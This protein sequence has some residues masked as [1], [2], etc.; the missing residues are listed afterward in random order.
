MNKSEFEIYETLD[1]EVPDISP[2]S[3]LYNL[4]P[5][6]IGTARVESLAS[7]ISRLAQEHFQTPIVL[8]KNSV[9]DLSELPK[10]LLQN[11]I[12]ASF[13]KSLNGFGNNTEQI[14]KILQKATFRNDIHK[15]T[16]LMWR[17]KL[18]KHKLLRKN[19]AW[20]SVCYEE[21]KENNQIVY[22]QLLWAF[23]KVSVC[24]LHEIPLTE[25]CP[26]CHN[27][28]KIL[29]RNFK[30]GY[31][32]RCSHWMGGKNIIFDE[33]RRGQKD[34]KHKIEMWKAIKLGELLSKVPLTA[35]KYNEKLFIENLENLIEEISF[36]SIND[37]AY[38][39]EMWHVSIRRLLKGEVL[40]TIEMLLKICTPLDISPA[41]LFIKK[42]KTK[43]PKVVSQNTNI[44][45]LSKNDFKKILYRFFDEYPPLSANEVSRRTGW[46]T[47]RI[48]RN[49][50]NEY[51]MIVKKYSDYIEQ[52]LPKLNNEEVKKILE[53][54][55]YEN[56]PP[57]LQSIFRKIGCRSTGYRYYHK[58]PKLCAKISKRYQKAN[59]KIFDVKKAEKVLKLAL[60]EVPAPSFSEIARRLKCS[61]T[62]L[63]TKFPN[64]SKRLHKRYKDHLDKK[65]K[66]NLQTLR[67]TIKQTIN[68][69]RKQLLPVSANSVRKNMPRKW[70][71]ETFVKEFA[72]I[73]KRM[74]F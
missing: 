12:N 26:H 8:L 21:Q 4:S 54:A 30:S 64:L 65:R 44:K 17:N 67:K 59:K 37:F 58:F 62:T 9:T 57:S 68:E 45:N 23:E 11:S 2:R 43:N 27:K 15:T 49:F 38:L 13:A 46:T 61:R 47:T 41:L 74:G 33:F 40:P 56:P 53:K 69:L 66:A 42:S 35:F 19:L 31:C 72:L 7:Y 50:P 39:T 29:G 28:L 36:G 14:V 1:I 6:E 20:C 48:Q 10:T 18:S 22:D 32:S 63:N 60:K 24:Y 5:L 25:L 55:C 51:E 16:L 70:N 3:R 52:K 34:E 73:R 71:D